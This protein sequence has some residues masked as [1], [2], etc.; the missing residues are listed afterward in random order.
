MVIVS[1]SAFLGVLFSSQ[2]K[3]SR[4]SAAGKSGALR[5]LLEASA[6][7]GALHGAGICGRLGDLGAIGADYDV[8]V[9]PKDLQQDR[10]VG[11]ERSYRYEV[12]VFFFS[13]GG[14]GGGGAA[15]VDSSFMRDK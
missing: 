3:A 2:A 7:G 12:V 11:V 5:A 14:M 1:L 9:R 13:V 15:Y 6:P 10:F 4:E 8:A